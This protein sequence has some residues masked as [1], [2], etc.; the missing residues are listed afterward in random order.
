[1]NELHAELRAR[2][3]FRCRCYATLQHTGET[4]PA[5]LLNL[6]DSGAL[7][8][9]LVPH[10]LDADEAVELCIE[11]SEGDIH[12]RGIIAHR[13]EHYIGVECNPISTRD[14]Q[15]LDHLLANLNQI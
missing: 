1:M 3:R 9:I 7:V 2:P 8:A 6:G 11:R 4:W 13:K 14:R 5:H 10:R 12:L 15:A